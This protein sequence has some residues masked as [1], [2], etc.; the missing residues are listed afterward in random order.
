M[1]FN[2]G[3]NLYHKASC[4]RPKNKWSETIHMTKIDLIYRK[5]PKQIAMNMRHNDWTTGSWDGTY[6][7]RGVKH[8]LLAFNLPLTWKSGG[9]KTNKTKYKNL[10]NLDLIMRSIQNINTS[11]NGTTSCIYLGK[12]SLFLKAIS[13]SKSSW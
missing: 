10:L 8:C 13:E 5:K 7:G 12:Y 9:K 3:Q 4:K 1:F 11:T 2:D 6:V